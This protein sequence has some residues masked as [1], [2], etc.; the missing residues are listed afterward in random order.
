MKSASQANIRQ[1]DQHEKQ[2]RR[3]PKKAAPKSPGR[4]DATPDD[5]LIL[6]DDKRRRRRRRA[7]DVDVVGKAHILRRD[8]GAYFSCAK[9]SGGKQNTNRLLRLGRSLHTRYA[10]KYFSRNVVDSS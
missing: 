1:G 6:I 5:W 3:C 4:R 8:A 2:V 10:A 9:S 7:S